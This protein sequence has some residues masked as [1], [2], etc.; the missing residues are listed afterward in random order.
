MKTLH[1]AAQTNPCAKILAHK[2]LDPRCVENGCQSLAAPA[3]PVSLTD[4]Q[5]QRAYKLGWMAASSWAKRYDLLGDIGSPAYVADMA[6]ALQ[7]FGI[8]K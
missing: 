5:L 4:E 7:I 1:E 8:G 6:D 2:W 3:Q